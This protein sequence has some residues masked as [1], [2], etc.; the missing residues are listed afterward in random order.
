MARLKP[1]IV[2]YFNIGS[3]LVHILPYYVM[4]GRR[5]GSREGGGGGGGR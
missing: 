4:I 3:L 5:R 1:A 2:F